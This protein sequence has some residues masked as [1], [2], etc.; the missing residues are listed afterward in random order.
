MW[1]RV[2]GLAISGCCVA[3]ACGGSSVTKES[4]DGEPNDA[5]QGNGGVS[6]MGG[7]SSGG[8]ALGGTAGTSMGG[9]SRGGSGGGRGGTTQTGGSGGNA[10]EP[11]GGQPNGGQAGEAAGGSGGE[12]GACTIGGAIV[13]TNALELSHFADLG[14]EVLEGSLTISS[15]TLTSLD[16]LSPSP[17]RVITGTLAIENNPVLDN[18][19]G[20]QGLVEI[21]SSLLIQSSNIGDLGGLNTLRSIGSNSESHAL[22]IANNARLESVTA[23]G[24]VTRLQTSVYVAGNPILG[25]LTGIGRLQATS[26]VVIVNHTLLWEIGG[27]TELEETRNLTVSGNTGLVDTS[28]PS[29]TNVESLTITG[30]DAVESVSL[31]VLASAESFTVAGNQTLVTLGTLDALMSVGSL[32]IGGN[33][34]LPQC[35]VDALDA[36]LMAC[37][38][39]CSG[40]DTTAVCN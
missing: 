25:S 15:P 40:N 1:V 9:S 30:N 19:E 12:P 24:G 13:I 35:F 21:G 32:I 29:L 2:F 31:P 20:L 33:P 23:L 8:R 39:T 27:L 36:R 22:M 6:V 5:G 14:C 3:V 37:N 17:L 7:T 18:L 11:A 4:N 16:I 38:M 26:S 28:F 10:G 34:R